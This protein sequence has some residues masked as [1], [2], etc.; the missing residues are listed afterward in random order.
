MIVIPNDVVVGGLESKVIAKLARIV[1]SGPQVHLHFFVTNPP[2]ADPILV[3]LVP[4]LDFSPP[5][6]FR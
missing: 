5:P 4:L 2:L 6:I 3:H 1:G